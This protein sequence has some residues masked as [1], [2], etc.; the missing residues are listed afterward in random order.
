MAKDGRGWHGEPR[1]HADAARGQKTAK[2]KV[3][4]GVRV[5]PVEQATS[6]LKLGWNDELPG[7]VE[8]PVSWSSKPVEKPLSRHFTTDALTQYQAGEALIR[9]AAYGS[10]PNRVYEYND[11]KPR[12]VGDTLQHMRLD[13]GKVYVGREGSPVI[14]FE[15]ASAK[16]VNAFLKNLKTRAPYGLPQEF[17]GPNDVPMMKRNTPGT[18]QNPAAH[19]GSTHQVWRLWWD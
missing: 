12:A 6:V 1:R 9:G 14:Y 11:F 4:R 16:A 18:G 10:L 17:G 7:T 8:Y 13:L 3:R 5:S 19:L 2:Q 15:G